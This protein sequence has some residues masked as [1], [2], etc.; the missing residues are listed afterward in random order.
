M[1]KEIIVCNCMEISKEEII[2][3]IN[4][5]GLTQVKEVHDETDAGTNCGCCIEDIQEILN[6][7]ND[8]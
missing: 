2:K 3:A 8:C 1:N 6:E 7:I 4:K 5:E